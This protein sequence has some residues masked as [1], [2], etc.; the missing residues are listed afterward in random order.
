[1]SR[2]RQLISLAVL[3]TP[4]LVWAESVVPV[5]ANNFRQLYSKESP[6]WLEAVGKLNVPGL[7]YALGRP[8]N[9]REQCSATL[10]A[11]PASTQANTIVT[12]WH[13]LEFYRDLSKVITFT[14]RNGTAKSFS[15]EARILEHGGGMHADWALLRLQSPV[16]TSTLAALPRLQR[17][18]FPWRATP[19][20]VKTAAS[21]KS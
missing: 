3:S 4:G 5:G 14:L 10:I 13:C 17:V 11:P 1:M 9:H 18:L 20:T 8:Q 7:K 21:E 19:M 15:I 16:P 12:A 6:Q 2:L